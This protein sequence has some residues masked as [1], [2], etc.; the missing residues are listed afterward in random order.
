[1]HKMISGLAGATALIASSVSGAA[2]AEMTSDDLSYARLTYCAALNVM[3]GQALGASE[4]IDKAEVKAQSDIFIAQAAALTM[5]AAAMNQIDPR[6]VEG[7]VFA[8]HQAM[9]QS[10]SRDGAPEELLQ[11]D[12]GSCNDLGKAAYEAVESANKG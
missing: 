8:Q 3:L 6:E 10:F 11:R 9:A 4:D 2:R 12:L 7:D 5:V 1:M